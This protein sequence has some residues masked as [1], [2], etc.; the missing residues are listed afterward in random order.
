MNTAI[1]FGGAGYIGQATWQRLQGQFQRIILADVR[2]PSVPLPAQVSFVMC[3]VRQPIEL[4]LAQLG[5]QVGEVDWIFHYSAIHREPGHAFEEYFDT[6][7]PGAE[8]VTA[9][10]EAW[11]VPNIYFT[12]S[13]AVYGPTHAPTN[14][15]TVKYPS[16][17]YGISKLTAELIHERWA[18]KSSE[19][20]LIVC[21]PGVV[22]GAGDPGNI[23]RMIRAVKKGIFVFPGSPHIHKSYAYIEGLLD[24]IE[25]TMARAEKVIHYNYVESPTEPLGALVTHIQDIL[26]KRSM[27]FR[28]PVGLLALVAQ[29]LQWLTLGKSPIHPK[30]V[31]KAAM[32]THIIPQWLIDHGFEFR[33]DFASSLRDWKQRSPG[34]F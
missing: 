32:P 28:A 14:E 26:G 30:R 22:Y 19:R 2:E 4:G 23:L 9:F 31:R 8:H 11:E 25:F 24:S 7:V 16:S 20:R 29:V 33:Y 27:N 3:D 10:A 6:N 5:V 21:R 34:D 1:I 15:S 13:I 17:G 12:A 18:A